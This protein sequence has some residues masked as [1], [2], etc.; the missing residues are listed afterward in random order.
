MVLCLIME[1]DIMTGG[2][3]VEETLSLMAG[4]RAKANAR[5]PKKDYRTIKKPDLMVYSG[6]QT[7]YRQIDTETNS[8]RLYPLLVALSKNRSVNCLCLQPQKTT[9]VLD[10][11]I[12]KKIK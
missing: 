3:S 2:A 1:W 5:T 6:N 9:V 4:V 11:V 10:L 8:I 12:D 7:P